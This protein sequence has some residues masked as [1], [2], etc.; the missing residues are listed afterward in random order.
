MAEYPTEGELA[1]IHKWERLNPFECVSRD[2]NDRSHPS[3]GGSCGYDKFQRQDLVDAYQNNMPAPT[4]MVRRYQRW[5]GNGID[6]LRMTGKKGS[7][8][9]LVLYKL[10]WP[11]S[12]NLECIAFIA[13]N[14][15][16]ERIYNEKDISKALL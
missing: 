9:L 13:N 3:W 12:T 5:I 4:R 2:D 10:I 7:Y 11:H 1:G 8:N 6:S 16:D 14:S 15:T